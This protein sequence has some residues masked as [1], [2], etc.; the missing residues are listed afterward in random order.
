MGRQILDGVGPASGEEAVIDSLRQK[1]LLD[2]AL[3]C[4][5][6]FRVGLRNGT[7][8]DLLAVDLRESLEGLGRITGEVVTQDILAEIFSRFCVGK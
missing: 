4:Y 5:R 6:E 1:E 2:R 8:L 7:S 3:V